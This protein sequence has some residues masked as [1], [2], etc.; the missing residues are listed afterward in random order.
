MYTTRTLV[1]SAWLWILK[2][3]EPI[4]HIRAFSRWH[5]GLVCG[6]ISMHHAYVLV[7]DPKRY[8]PV[9]IITQTKLYEYTVD[10]IIMAVMFYIGMASLMGAVIAISILIKLH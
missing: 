10:D 8:P 6:I 3:I 1:L 9:S 4:T 5:E 2:A 7:V